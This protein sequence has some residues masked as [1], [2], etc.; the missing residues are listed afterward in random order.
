MAQQI[1]SFG[2]LFRDG[3]GGA[4]PF[5]QG[6][7]GSIGKVKD[8]APDEF[9]PIIPFLC[10]GEPHVR[11]PDMEGTLRG[12]EIR[13]TGLLRLKPSPKRGHFCFGFRDAAAFFIFS[14][15]IPP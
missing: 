2:K 15:L 13:M 6:V 10:V 4:F 5:F 7:H 12:I 8:I 1:G 14:V 3:V 11:L 9:V